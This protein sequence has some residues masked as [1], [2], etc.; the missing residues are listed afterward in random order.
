M[1]RDDA[2]NKER[3][4]LYGR[5]QGHKLK[6]RQAALMEEL[7]PQLKINLEDAQLAKPAT[8]FDPPAREVWVEIGFGGGEHLSAQAQNNPDIG[9]LGAEPFINGVAKLLSEIEK[10]NLSNVRIHDDDARSLLDEL[11]DET[12]S[13]V[14]LLYPDPWPKTRHNKRRFVGRDNL[15]RLHR[16]LKTGGLFRFA[17]DIPDYVRWTLREA[18]QHGGFRW[19]AETPRDWRDAP[20]GWPGTRYEAKALREGRVPAYL[21][22]IKK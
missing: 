21:D 2:K 8:L 14:F 7:L 15:D 9:I 10:E 17:S 19:C 1:S 13:R 18:H 12:I 20:E 3:R 6:G 11:G 5:R 16:I 4:L 22:F